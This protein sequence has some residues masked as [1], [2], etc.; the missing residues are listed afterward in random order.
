M[1]VRAA[2]GITA[3]LGVVTVVAADASAAVRRTAIVSARS[4][5]TVTGMP[6][7]KIVRGRRG[8]TSARSRRRTGM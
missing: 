8:T 5:V 1:P 7:A 4:D 6:R 2:L 3:F